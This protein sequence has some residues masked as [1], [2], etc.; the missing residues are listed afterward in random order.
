MFKGVKVPPPFF[1]LI[2]DIILYINIMSK[3]TTTGFEPARAEPNGLAV[4]RLN[5]SAM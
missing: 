1:V 5:L 3:T 2:I 4:H